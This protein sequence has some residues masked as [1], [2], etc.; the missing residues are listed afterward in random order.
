MLLDLVERLI[1]RC[2]GLV[3]EHQETKRRLLQDVV[4]PLYSD[5]LSVHSEYLAC[6]DEYR[7]LLR[8]DTEFAMKAPKLRDRLT[9]DNLFTSGQRGKL[10]QLCSLRRDDDSASLWRLSNI[11]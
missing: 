8:E 2:I 3:K 1:E 7:V 9:K 10:L 6:F 5:F 11:I 4:D